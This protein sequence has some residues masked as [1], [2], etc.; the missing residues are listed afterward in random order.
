MNE[1]KIVIKEYPEAQ[2][3]K[4]T[5]SDCDQDIAEVVN[6]IAKRSSH[7]FGFCRWGRSNHTTLM[8]HRFEGVARVYPN[9]GDVYDAQAGKIIAKNKCVEKYN[10]S[11]DKKMIKVV[12][13]AENFV[14]ALKDY[15]DKHYI[16]Y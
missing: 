4:A 11:F 10:K 3:V 5:M 2:V 16:E 15:C 6:K 8:K 14:K 13:D 12:H 7:Y 1:N 9:S